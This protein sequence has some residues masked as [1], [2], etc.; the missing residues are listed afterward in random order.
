VLFGFSRWAALALTS[1]LVLAACGAN[2]GPTIPEG[3]ALDESASI[4]RQSAWGVRAANP[5]A[6]PNVKC[7][8]RFSTCYTVS[9]ANGL[10]VPWCYGPK[11]DPCSKS[12]VKV[13]DHKAITW[14]G[15]VCL[16]KG[17]T[18]PEPIA[19]MTAKWTGPFKCKGSAY[20][21]KGTYEVD[22]ITPG[23]GL[24]ETA[25]Y[26]YKQD[27]RVCVGSSCEDLLIGLNVG[28]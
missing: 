22:T 25:Q 21:C 10:K 15:V 4:G 26:L 3:S 6:R 7:P 28:S 20:T 27:A 9:E 23:P 1:I 2:N 17:N 14:S 16:A 24:H 5:S 8:K 18:C 12:N 13:W 19:Q 11:S